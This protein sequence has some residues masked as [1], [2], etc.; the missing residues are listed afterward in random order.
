MQKGKEVPIVMLVSMGFLAA[1]C[2]FM[3]LFPAKIMTTINQVNTHLLGTNIIHTITL[4]DWLQ[5]E[6]QSIPIL[7]SYLQKALQ[8]LA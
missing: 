2:V 5:N 7:Q 8:Y 4:Y 3:G 1:L 6:G